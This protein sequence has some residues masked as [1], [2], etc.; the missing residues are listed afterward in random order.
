MIGMATRVGIAFGS[1]RKYDWVK[2]EIESIQGAEV[3]FVG[4][5]DGLNLENAV[6]ADVILVHGTSPGPSFLDYMTGLMQ[7]KGAPPMMVI[8]E[9]GQYVRQALRFKGMDIQYLSELIEAEDLKQV[10]VTKSRKSQAR[11]NNLNLQWIGNI[12]N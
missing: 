8:G 12:L 10:I 3:V 1:L 6:W 7:A 11:L 2:E 9:A 5:D 4:L